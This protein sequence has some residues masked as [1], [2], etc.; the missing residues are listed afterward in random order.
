MRFCN[1]LTI[2]TCGF[3]CFELFFFSGMPGPLTRVR[4][5]LSQPCIVRANLCAQLKLH[6][7]LNGTARDVTPRHNLTPTQISTVREPTTTAHG[8]RV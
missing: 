4:T 3:F 2:D 8:Y 5:Q 7:Q 6:A 1:V